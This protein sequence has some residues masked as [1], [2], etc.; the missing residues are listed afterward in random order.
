MRLVKLGLANVNTTVGAL[1]QNVDKALQWAHQMAGDGVTVGL[2]QEQLIGGYPCED[3]IQWRGFVEHQWTQ[4]VRFAESTSRLHSVFVLG[5]VINHH[6]LQH[7]CVVLV[8]G[9][10]GVGLVPKEKLPTYGVFYEG[11]T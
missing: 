4:L 1:S 10:Q 5:V 9:G 3:L 2:F 6:G 7:S 11:P 8:G